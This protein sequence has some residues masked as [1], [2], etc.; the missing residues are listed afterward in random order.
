MADYYIIDKETRIIRG[1]TSDANAPIENFE[2]KILV[3]DK[4]PLQ[5]NTKLALNDLDYLDP[6]PEEIEKYL[7][8]R[9]PRRV[10][11]REFGQFV[12]DIQSDVDIPTKIKDFVKKVSEL[13]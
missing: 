4:K 10:K 5:P 6:T 8:R 2:E 3:T 12:Q 11:I 9:N 13:I 1:M 7:D